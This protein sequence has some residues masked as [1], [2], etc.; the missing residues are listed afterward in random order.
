M[1]KHNNKSISFTSLGQLRYLSALQYVDAMVGNSSSGIVEAPS[2]KIGT[3]NISDRQKGRVKAN[4]VIDCLPNKE[5]IKS[6]FKTLYS[7][8]FQSELKTTK[9]P[10]GDSCASKKIIKLLKNVQL[11]NILKKDFFDIKILS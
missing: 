11:D 5:S 2:F 3:I 1:T 6:G 4:S 8:K 9:N 7:K 10:Y